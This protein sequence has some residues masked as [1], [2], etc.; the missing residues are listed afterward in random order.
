MKVKLRRIKAHL[1]GVMQSELLIT[2][3][4][5]LSVFFFFFFFFFFFCKISD[6]IKLCYLYNGPDSGTQMKCHIILFI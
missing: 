6:T 5:G 3:P 1:S 2:Q 4:H